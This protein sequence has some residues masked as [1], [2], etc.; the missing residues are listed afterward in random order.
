MT[1]NIKD[2]VARL[3]RDLLERHGVDTAL[4]GELADLQRAS[5]I[6]HGS[7][8]ISPFLRPYFLERT[9]YDAIRRAARILSL[10]FESVTAAALKSDALMTELGVSEKEARWA[11][12]EPRYAGVSVNSRLDTFLTADGF[13]FLEYNAENPAGI[14]DQP[15]LE[16]LFRAVPAVNE[17][18]S[19]NDHHFPQ[20]H[21]RLLDVL[22][23]AYRDFGGKKAKPNIGIVDWA[24]VSTAPEFG[25]LKEYF[26][27]SGH[28]AR[29]CD[30][31]ELEYRDSHL[32]AAG[33]EIDVF[34]KRVII[35]EFLDKF[36]ETH[37]LYL[38]CQDGAVCMA[39]S[40]RSKIPHKKAGFAVLT[41]GRYES[42]FTNEQLAVIREHVPWTRTVSDES[43]TYNG[44]TI[45]LLE[46]IRA[47]RERFVL[48]PND[49]YGG[50]GI[51][52]GWE[53]SEREWDDAIGHALD[54]HHLVQERVG[55]EKTDIPLISEGEARMASLTVDFDPFLFRGEVEGGMVRLAPGSLVNISSGGGETALAILEGY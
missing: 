1:T 34:F 22:V 11:R 46:F 25:I 49:D 47:T 44:K 21:V 4:F 41:D 38:A 48:K 50:K 20:P 37:P 24:G 35:H 42:M 19:A 36:D 54:S 27:K 6:L 23:S 18:L 39:N 31:N 2:I 12:L 29:I 30:P 28:T 40:F 52:F 17:F 33:F 9:R 3:D 53:S 32:T 55:V 15:S 51:S 13:A 26:E 7:R 5:G 16:R 45:E 43:T 14:G 10:A 8:P